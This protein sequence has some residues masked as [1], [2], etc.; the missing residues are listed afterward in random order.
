MLPFSKGIPIQIQ[1][2]KFINKLFFQDTMVV[3]QQKSRRKSTGGRFKHIKTKRLNRFGNPPSLTKVGKLKTKVLKTKG[4]NFKTRLQD[5]DIANV[6]DK[7]KGKYQK[8]KILNV[9]E[10]PA[11][12]HYVRRN[13]ITKGTV[14]KT[15]LGNARVTNRPGQEGIINAVLVDKKE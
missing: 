10:N 14:L 11:N 5:S 6:L 9:I 3:N 15:D 8:A 2:K 7:K 13:I 1:S 4:G 12:R